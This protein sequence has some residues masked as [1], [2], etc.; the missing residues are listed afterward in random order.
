ML[1]PGIYTNVAFKDYLAI[2]AI[3]NSYLG[4]LAECPA[5]ALVPSEDTPS[6][7]IGRA[8]HKAV[9]EG[10]D[11]FNAEFAIGPEVD[12]RTKAGKEEWAAFEAENQ[13]KVILKKEDSDKVLCV[14]NAVFRHPWAS[15]LLADGVAEQTIIFQDFDSGLLCKARPD[16]L[17]DEG[18]RTMVDLKTTR[19]AG[20][21]AF[22]RSI[23][24]YGYARQAAFY[25]DGMNAIRKGTL[26]NT[27]FDLF[28]FIAVETET[29]YRV[30]VYALSSDFI[31]YGR[32]E[33]QRL[34]K[35]E[36][37][38]RKAG[39]Y[40]HYSNEGIVEIYKPGWLI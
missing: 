27:F 15:K 23:I 40:P 13:S 35:V 16:C 10:Q 1:T 19:G 21:K 37:E 33:Y 5:K 20:G 8:V 7:I 29:P 32:A 18:K 26:K 4:R 11:A 38:C 31:E 36:I 34:L 17:P 28:V 25:L 9:L 30:E 22:T 12:K 24:D 3:S 14:A 2:E 6:L 39:T